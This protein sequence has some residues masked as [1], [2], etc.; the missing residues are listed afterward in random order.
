MRL[1]I[2]KPGPRIETED[3]VK[4]LKDSIVDAYQTG[5]LLVHPDVMSYEIVEFDS[6]VHDTESLYP[7][8]PIKHRKED[9]KKFREL[10]NKR[11]KEKGEKKNDD[12]QGNDGENSC[13]RES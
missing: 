9:M 4:A 3:E 13:D 8:L 2:I 5:I 10:M 7:T 12:N 1:L 6:I 11:L